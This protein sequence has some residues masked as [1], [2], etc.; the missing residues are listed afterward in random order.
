M[1]GVGRGDCYLDK[2]ASVLQ[3]RTNDLL[4]FINGGYLHLVLLDKNNQGNS[5][6]PRVNA[7]AEFIYRSQ[8]AC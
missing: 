5:G 8:V 4:L 1:V 6:G 2:K 7:L 3:D